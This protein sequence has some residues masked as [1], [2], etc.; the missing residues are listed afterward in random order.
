M[1]LDDVL[2]QYQTEIYRFATHLTRNRADAD[3][4]YQQTLLEASRAFDRLDG[5]ANPRA[6][7]YTIATNTF[8]RDRHPCGSERPLA[9]ERTAEFPGGAPARGARPAAS[10]LL[11]EVED[12]VAALPRRQWVAL[13]Q[14]QVP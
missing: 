11:R 1:T 8:L 13:V 6:W 10:D 14:P 4:L 5:T 9:E 2:A 7:L 3:V 12:F